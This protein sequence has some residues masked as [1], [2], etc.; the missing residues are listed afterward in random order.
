MTTELRWIDYASD[1]W[2][3]DHHD[4]A[5]RAYREHIPDNMRPKATTVRARGEEAGCR[6]AKK[7]RLQVGNVADVHGTIFVVFNIFAHPS[8][9]NLVVAFYEAEALELLDGVDFASLRD[10]D[11]SH[12]ADLYAR[13]HECVAV[14]DY[15]M[16]MD[17]VKHS[18]DV[19]QQHHIPGH[20]PFLAEAITKAKTSWGRLFPSLYASQMSGSTFSWRM[21][22]RSR[23]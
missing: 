15:E 17:W 2:F 21:F 11:P 13:S 6:Q 4:G 9:G 23:M 14:A 8:S 3:A 20:P 5:F 1:R 16:V 10:L 7:R 12:E 22:H 18:D 19:G